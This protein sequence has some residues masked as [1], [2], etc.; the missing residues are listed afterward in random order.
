METEHLLYI[1]IGLAALNLILTLTMKSED[2]RQAKMNDRVKPPAKTAGGAP[3]NAAAKQIPDKAA[4]KHDDVKK[5]PAKFTP[6][7][8][9]S[10][11]SKK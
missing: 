6:D 8:K 1:V 10:P 11:T 3:A 4:A 7:V 9:K 5:S 2:Y